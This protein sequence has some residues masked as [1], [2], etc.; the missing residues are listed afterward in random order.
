MTSYV[1]ILVDPSLY[2]IMCFQKTYCGNHNSNRMS[3]FIFPMNVK[4]W[5]KLLQRAKFVNLAHNEP[6]WQASLQNKPPYSTITQSLKE[7]HSRNTHFLIVSVKYTHPGFELRPHSH[8]PSTFTITTIKDKLAGIC[9]DNFGNFLTFMKIQKLHVLFAWILKLTR[10]LEKCQYTK[11]N[12]NN[13]P[14]R[15]PSSTLPQR[16]RGKSLQNNRV[17]VTNIHHKS[18][19]MDI[20]NYN[21]NNSHHLIIM[22]KKILK[23]YTFT[24]VAQRTEKFVQ[25][26]SKL[27]CL[28][29]GGNY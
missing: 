20:Y 5:A 3:T 24:Q 7:E 8:K 26:E 10:S 2:M 21:K 6:A 22:F 19:I 16:P 25:F 12:L 28:K 14:G 18:N 11:L 13:H 23:K 4:L 9:L 15:T 1:N 29:S 17:N 27:S